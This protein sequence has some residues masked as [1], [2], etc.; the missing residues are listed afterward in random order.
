MLVFTLFNEKHPSFISYATLQMLLKWK[1]EYNTN[2]AGFQ[3]LNPL[4][5]NSRQKLIDW[6]LI[7]MKTKSFLFNAQ[8][9][10]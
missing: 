5:R 2:F 6:T 9:Q 10:A 1:N 4:S 8:R 3:S 7:K